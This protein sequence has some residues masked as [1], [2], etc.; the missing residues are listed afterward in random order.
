ML[1]LLPP[2]ET[3]AGGGE[4]PPLELA[5]LWLPQLT[6]TR[7]TLAQ[8]LVELADDFEASAL[9]LKLGPKQAGEG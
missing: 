8:A 5:E 6:D 7:E 2:S 3:K 1:I 4:G 9:A